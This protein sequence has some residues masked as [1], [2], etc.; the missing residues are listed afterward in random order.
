ME[1]RSVWNI[2][3][4]GEGESEKANIETHPETLIQLE[5]GKNLYANYME[6]YHHSR[7]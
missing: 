1:S 3:L 5:T 2:A 6:G 7:A 4:P